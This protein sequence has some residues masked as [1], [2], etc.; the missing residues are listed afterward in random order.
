MGPAPL[1]LVGA[2]GSPYTRKLRA[3]LRFRRIEHLFIIRNS[4]ADRGIPDVPVALMPVL[5][6]P[7]VAGADDEAMIDSTFQI[8]R[9]EDAFADRSVVPPDP[10]MAFLDF[11]IEDYADEW[12]T[13][14]MFH[15][16]WAYAPDIA[17]AGAVLP[18]WSRVNASDEA[19]APV[20][21][22][23]RE[24]QIGR[25]AVVGSNETTAWV[26]ED[27][28]R[29]LLRGLDAH[30]TR[31]P[32]VMGQRPGAADFALFG[33]LTQLVLFDPTPAAI[34]LEE[35]PRVYAWC[36]V[37]EDL[38]GLEVGDGDW[39]SR[40]AIP[41]T[42]GALLAEVGRVY[43]PF[44]LANAA[45][46]ASGAARVEAEIAGRPWVQKPFPYQ[47]KC[48][49]WLRE[50]RASLSGGGLADVDSV[51]AGTGCEALFAD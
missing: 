45:A 22:L 11:L 3:L 43:P 30:L 18:H 50:S 29:R 28:Y 8:R 40:D 1:K 47:G 23:F 49:R 7:G 21:K 51:L 35:S 41:D 42:L 34:A 2:P 38:S 9:L 15:Y 25:L 17:K 27:S 4:V 6:F 26:I 48:L 5:V 32:Y 24:R 46:L 16:R 13:K 20:S 31:Q 37:L 12:L 14:A 10:V 36:E 39:T 19:I 33:Q 44:L